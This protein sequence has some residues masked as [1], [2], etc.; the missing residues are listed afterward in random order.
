[1]SEVQVVT[2]A[3]SIVSALAIIMG[4]ATAYLRL[5]VKG[6]VGSLKEDIHKSLNDRFMTKEA[7]TMLAE[8]FEKQGA[9]LTRSTDRELAMLTKDLSELTEEV[10]AIKY[11]QVE[12]GR[13]VDDIQREV[14]QHHP[15][16]PQQEKRQEPPRK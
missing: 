2:I 14:H 10:V 8:A 9:N 13:R 12:I 4:A 7:S 15:F 6:E 1:M 5:F 11:R 16:T 3:V